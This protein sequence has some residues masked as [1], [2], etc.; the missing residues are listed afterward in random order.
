[1][2]NITDASVWVRVRQEN[3]VDQDY[4][5][6]SDG[7]F[8]ITAALQ[9]DHNGDGRVNAADYTAWRKTNRGVPAGYTTWRT[10]FGEGGGTAAVPELSSLWIL[11]SGILSIYTCRMA[12]G[13]R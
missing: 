3:N 7:S 4:E 10:H 11:L 13:G 9:G 12:Y 8:S 2:P 5:D 1:V 6:I